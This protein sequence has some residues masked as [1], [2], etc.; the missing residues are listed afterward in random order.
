VD[1]AWRRRDIATAL[2]HTRL[3]WVF[4]RTDEAFFVTGAENVAS[5][6][7]HAA[8]GFQEVKRFGSDRFASG[9]GVLSRLARVAGEPD[10][11]PFVGDE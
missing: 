8:L 1:P 7:L 5:L 3:D 4:A 11:R 10:V 2:T 9:V 6:R